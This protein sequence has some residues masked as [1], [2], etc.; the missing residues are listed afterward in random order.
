ML[1]I[2][3]R[4]W[5]AGRAPENSLEALRAVLRLPIDGVEIDIRRS[6]DGRYFVRHDP[7]FPDGAVLAG[8]S[9]AAIR[10]RRLANGE[11]IPTL[12]EFLAGA[13]RGLV[14][15]D[16]K[17]SCRPLDVADRALSVLPA[18]RL[19]FSS[20]WHPGILE[21]SK[22]RPGLRLGVTV[23]A[24]LARPA[25]ALRAAGA[26]V[27][28]LPASCADRATVVDVRRAGGEVWCW[29]VEDVETARALARQGVSALI[30]DHPRELSASRRLPRPRLPRA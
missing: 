18:E 9:A 26:Q 16:L 23:E 7:A 6:A 27:L 11:P 10:R 15:L 21:L 25:D 1:R 28:V 8:L 24:R 5:Q 29:A 13:A 22:R 20:F 19:F 3:H 4:A 17:E 14:F 30:T 2:A 12:E